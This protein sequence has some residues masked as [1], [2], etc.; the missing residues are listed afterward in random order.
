M[1]GVVAL[2]AQNAFDQKPDVRLVVDNQDFMRH[3][4]SLSVVR[5][6]RHSSRR[7]RRENEAGHGTARPPNR[8]SRVTTA[9]M[10]LHD[11][12]DDG[13]TKT[14]AFWLMRDVRLGQTGTIL[15]GQAD[16]R[17]RSPRWRSSVAVWT[18]ATSMWPTQSCGLPSALHRPA[19]R[20]GAWR[21]ESAAF[22]Q[23]V[24]ER[25]ARAT[26]GRTPPVGPWSGRCV[27]QPISGWACAL[28]HHRLARRCGQYPRG[29]ITGCG[30]R[31]KAD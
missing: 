30:M 31:A 4:R 16:D 18:M 20:G 29:L 15:G 13:K 10:V 14:G 24:G 17:H 11:L 12:L 2:V 7:H 19:R 21:T 28:Q 22:M 23:Q 8:S 9:G 3:R 1:A 5:R 26:G 6:R 25:L 27:A